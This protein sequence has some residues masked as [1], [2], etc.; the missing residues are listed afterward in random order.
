LEFPEFYVNLERKECDS[1]FMFMT[2]NQKYCGTQFEKS[3]ETTLQLK[4][5][6][7]QL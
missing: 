2:L 7:S 6:R 5:M 3:T 4:L 1:H